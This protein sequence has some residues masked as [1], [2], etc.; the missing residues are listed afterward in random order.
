MTQIISVTR[1]F[2]DKHLVCLFF[3]ME[4]GRKFM[5]Q[6]KTRQDEIYPLLYMQFKIAV[7]FS[8]SQFMHLHLKILSKLASTSNFVPLFFFVVFF[9]LTLFIYLFI[10]L[11]SPELIISDERHRTLCIKAIDTLTLSSAKS[12]IPL[13]QEL[14]LQR[15]DSKWKYLPVW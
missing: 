8:N 6:W 12:A 15:Y 3:T 10:Y 1:F 4:F 11:M 13:S 14:I 9:I 5:W 2:C 7:W